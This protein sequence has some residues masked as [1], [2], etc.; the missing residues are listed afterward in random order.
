M[1]KSKAV[2]GNRINNL[3]FADN[4]DLVEGQIK[5]IAENVEILRRERKTEIKP[6]ITDISDERE[7]DLSGGGWLE[8]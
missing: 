6:K 3:S 5:T 1:T 4:I 2:H 8:Y 7:H